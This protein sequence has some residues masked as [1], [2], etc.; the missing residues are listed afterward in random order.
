[1]KHTLSFSMT[2]LSGDEQ[3]DEIIFDTKTDAQR[4]LNHI[5]QEISPCHSFSIQPYREPPSMTFD[6]WKIRFG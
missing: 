5:K 1:M 2:L 6:E 3:D 4:A